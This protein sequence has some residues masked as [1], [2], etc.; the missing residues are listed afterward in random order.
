MTSKRGEQSLRQGDV[1]YVGD[2]FNDNMDSVRV[3]S[4]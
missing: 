4:R 1:P 2:R 3:W